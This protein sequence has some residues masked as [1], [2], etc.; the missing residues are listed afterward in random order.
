MDFEFYDKVDKLYEKVREK[1]FYKRL[2]DKVVKEKILVMLEKMFGI[3]K[4]ESSHFFT[5]PEQF[6]L[7]NKEE[8]YAGSFRDVFLATIPAAKQRTLNLHREVVAR[9]TGISIKDVKIRDRLYEDRHYENETYDMILENFMNNMKDRYHF[10]TSENLDK[11]AKKR[12]GVRFMM[13]SRITDEGLEWSGLEAGKG[14]GGDSEWQKIAFVNSDDRGDGVVI[15]SAD[16]TDSKSPKFFHIRIAPEHADRIKAGKKSFYVAT[17]ELPYEVIKTSDDLD[18][19]F[20]SVLKAGMSS[21][22][23]EM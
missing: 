4:G 16:M 19:A 6:Q 23:F 12:N 15:L 14:T 2:S 11:N 9:E 8:A 1:E 17:K 18:E 3:D 21:P 22:S 5:Y 7:L 20:N 10:E 13:L